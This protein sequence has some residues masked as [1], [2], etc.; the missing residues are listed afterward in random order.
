MASYVMGDI[1]GEYEM[2]QEL[3]GKMN[4]NEG[5]TLYVMGD[6]IDRG[7]YPARVLRKLMEMKGCICLMGNHEDMALACR[8]F[9]LCNTEKITEE[10]YD[11]YTGEDADKL[12]DWM[13]NGY[14][15]TVR[16]FHDRLFSSEDR[17]KMVD[18]MEG[19]PRYKELDVSGQKS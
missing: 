18:F 19:F 9:L 6:L 8:K 2:L 14:G 5:D 13:N 17:E 15:T 11:Q 4:L 1:H 12:F 7:P 3:L 16:D 10:L